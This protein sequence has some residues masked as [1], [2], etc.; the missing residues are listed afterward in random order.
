MMDENLI[1]Y[2]LNALEADDHRRT[3]EYLR[4][5]PEAKRKLELVRAALKPLEADRETIN[6][7]TGLVDRTMAKVSEVFVRR[8]RIGVAS[9]DSA[10]FAPNRWR[11]MDVLVACSILIL[12][13][14]LGASGLV[15]FKQNESRVNCQNTLRVVDGAC[16]SYASTHQ[17]QL[18]TISDQP[19]YNRAGAYRNILVESGQLA[20]DVRTDCPAGPADAVNTTYAYHLPYRNPESKL[21][22]LYRGP[23]RS[24]PGTLPIMADVPQIRTHGQGFNV[25]YNGGHV[26][27]VTTP[28]VGIGG[29]DIFLNEL[30][31]VAP[32]LRLTDSVLAP[33]D[34]TPQ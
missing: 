13:G 16:S 28:N 32:G 3:E 5:H 11:R 8:Q 30:K 24:D 20:P 1:G 34:V 14:G 23:G 6:P 31:K 18:P 12:V 15:R 27:Y 19:P 25:L 22:G 21:S 26:S 4:D 2:A 17:G 29:D 10:F 33:A 7:P 9:R